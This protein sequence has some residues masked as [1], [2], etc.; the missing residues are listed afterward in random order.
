MG[1]WLEGKKNRGKDT[2]I[3]LLEFRGEE[4][5]EVRA[6]GAARVEHTENFR[7]RTGEKE[8]E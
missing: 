8:K 6:L 5:R 1:I 7:G 4:N 3:I 2:P